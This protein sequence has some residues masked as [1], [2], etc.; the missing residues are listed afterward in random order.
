MP[1]RE[2]GVS[3]GKQPE[4]TEEF[5]QMFVEAMGSVV[6]GPPIPPDEIESWRGKLPDLVLTWW[7]QVGLASFG[8]GRAWFTDPAEWVDVAAEILPLCQVISPYLDPALLN[9]AYYPWMRDAFGDMYCWS[10]THQVKLKITPLLHWVGG[11]DYSEDIANGLVTLPVENAI[12]SRPRDFDVVDD[13]GKLLFSRLRKRLGPLT[14]DTY[15]AM[16]VPV[17]LGGA[18]LADNFAIKPVHGHLAQ[19]STN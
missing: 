17:A 8:D 5:L 9:G 7:E 2:V 19:G 13:K 14:A 4:I 10:P 3:V 16:V 12:L 15:Y 1:A 6:P 18:V 11:A